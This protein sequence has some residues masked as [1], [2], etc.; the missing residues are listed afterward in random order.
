MPFPQYAE[1]EHISITELAFTCFTFDVHER[2]WLEEKKKNNVHASSF[3]NTRSEA[4]SVTYD[5]AASRALNR[6]KTDVYLEHVSSEQFC[7][8]CAD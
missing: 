2:D 8:V 3:E 6:I 5:F 7:A 1:I 4:Y